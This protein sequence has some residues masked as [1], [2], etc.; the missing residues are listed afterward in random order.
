MTLHL[1]PDWQH[2]LWTSRYSLRFELSS[3]E[4]F[5]TKL[6][7]SYDRARCLARKALPT[8]KILAVVATN[9]DPS[10]E[11]SAEWR[12]WVTGTGF[13]HLAKLGVPTDSCLFAWKGYW[14]PDDVD[15][16]EAEPWD[17]RAVSITWEQADI[18]IWNQVAH[19]LGMAPTAPVMSKLVD[20]ERGVCV[21]IYDDRGMDVISLTE[22][23]T[24]ELYSE[25]HDWLLDYDRARM[26]AVF[27]TG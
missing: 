16:P 14:W 20:I 26:A 3:G 1:G 13:D 2:D 19:D 17:Q 9:P 25:F 11:V 10:M 15:D 5:V 27:E 6:T 12:G 4:S 21:N 22:T 24:A 23:P 8:E 18:L 7:T